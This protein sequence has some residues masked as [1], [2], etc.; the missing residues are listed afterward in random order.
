MKT[1]LNETFYISVLLGT[2]KNR[3]AVFNIQIFASG[4]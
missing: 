2:K 3:V 1:L 4:V